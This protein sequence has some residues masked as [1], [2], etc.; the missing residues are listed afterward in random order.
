LKQ[1]SNGDPERHEPMKYV[2]ALLLVLTFLPLNGFAEPASR[3]RDGQVT[4]PLSAY[5]QMLQ[6]LSKPLRP[7]PARYAIGQS[8][9]SVSIRKNRD[10]FTAD[11]A[12]TLRVE[13]FEDGW[14][15]VPLL[16]TGTVLRH[17]FVNGRA[18]QL[19]QMPDGLAWSTDKAASVTIR[20]DY[21]VDARRSPAGFVL[22]L[23]VPL[24]SATELSLDVP[25]TGLDLGIVP[26]SNLKSVENGDRTRVTAAIP[27]T[28]SI[29]V[30]W[31][32]GSGRPYVVGQ[33]DY[34]G[35]VVGKAVTWSAQFRVEKFEE[36]LLSLPLVPASVTLSGIRVDGRPATALAKD[37]QFAVMLEGTGTK[38]VAVDFQVPVV[39]E[40]GPPFVRI[41]IP[42]VPV[43][44]FE[45]LLPGKKSV[46]VAPAASVDVDER[47]DTTKATVYIPMSDHVT[48][49]W[50]EAIPETLRIPYRA[51]ASLYHTVNAEE[52]VLHGRAQIVM[53][54]SRGETSLLEF[55]IAADTQVNRIVASAGGLSDWTE[56]DIAGSNRKK[57]SVFLEVPV[58]GEYGLDIFY[59]RLLGD[60]AETA[61][62]V[63]L[64]NARNVHRQR[65]MVALLS[66]KELALK[67]A[68]E[69]GL[70]RVGENQL[71]AFVR[72]QINMTVAHTYKYID[73]L[74]TLTVEPVEP[75]RRQ[76]KFDAQVD[77]LISL[78]DVIMK[79]SAGVAVDVKSGAIM[80]LELTLPGDVNI[81]GVSGPS[82][83][84]HQIRE[85]Q[86][87]QV[88]D[89]AF[90]REMEG[91]FRIDV[92]YERIMASDGSDPDVPTV[93]VT[94]AEVEQGRIAIEALTAVEVRASA[95]EQLASL[96][97]NEL[98][99]QLVLKTTNPILMAYRYVHA[100][101][102]VRLTLNITRHKEIDVQVA[103]IERAHYS[104]LITRDGLAVTSARFVVRN[105]RRQFLRL[106]LPEG[107]TMWSVFVDG[108]P[109]K[110]A[111][112]NNGSDNDNNAVLIKMINSVA[113]FPVDIVYA[114][115]VQ[116]M[117]YL[118][119]IS[120]RLPRPDM[121]VTHSRWSV[122]LPI[123]P[124]YQTPDSTLDPV[125]QG[126]TTNLRR[127]DAH[128]M[129]Q[130]RDGQR[131][132]S[133]QPLKIVVPTQ[134]VL[135]A[136]EK[137][138]ANQ[139]P[140]AA[141]FEI[142]YTAASTDQVAVVA[143]LLGVALIWIA[144]MA[145]ASGRIPLS[146]R[147][148]G[149][150]LVA[151]CGLI[152]VTIGFLGASPLPASLTAFAIAAGMVF[153]WLAGRLRHMWS[154]HRRSTPE[155]QPA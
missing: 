85:V 150:A 74:P 115:P 82:L 47:E 95:S 145:I 27:A 116:A 124:N 62:P 66:G 101:P 6:Q 79:G 20:L 34:S 99:Q 153:W 8:N 141:E 18:A 71:P 108:K 123:G 91:Q 37:G 137:L 19:V 118:G 64:L 155:D 103:A 25:A 89:L 38:R 127:A 44:R 26:S 105:S 2:I 77:T 138:Y 13:T 15:L 61:V 84:A 72:N 3:E 128:L 41:P 39:E 4:V 55:E 30:S 1:Q 23:P 129:K 76:G 29:L 65:G 143:S 48:F 147:A 149:A 151:G 56:S 70:S 122:Y 53:E 104:T 133:N 17:A 40:G 59:E 148:T 10:H 142:I 16:P 92:N 36:G 81:L 43:S 154:E 57:I 97:I 93:S 14:T 22:P 109:E 144:I 111:F 102:P 88:I 24:A 45:L 80:T 5:T 94:A 140:K 63:P 125:V 87:R 68:T 86:G 83:R 32:Q 139:S 110:P 134:G 120:S 21:G 9:V 100:R 130:V 106:M 121:V 60:A 135:F 69:E 51:N 132:Q 12:V 31:R 126:V 146:R 11:V 152:V 119:K 67:P 117:E 50:S 98:P 54:I 73:P 112:A 58:D 52:G 136:F 90:T 35:E 49:S 131:I 46:K 75:E 33:A 96:D 42:K 107:S 28:S 78:G 113:G 7:V 114:T